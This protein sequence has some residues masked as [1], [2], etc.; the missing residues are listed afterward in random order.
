MHKLLEGHDPDSPA[1]GAPSRAPLTYG[2]LRQLVRDTAGALNRIGIGRGDRVA[3]SLANG[4][5][6]AAAFVAI[7][8]AAT[9]APLNPNY[10]AAELEFYLRDLG[11]GLLV[12]ADG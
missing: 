12:V 6:M 3:L 8:S 2:G 5:E 10:R 4:P 1:I 11:A 9:L 7:G